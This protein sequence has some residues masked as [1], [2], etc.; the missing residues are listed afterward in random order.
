LIDEIGRFI[1]R[2]MNKDELIRRCPRLY[3]MAEAGSWPSIKQLGLLS[4]TAL[5]D[6]F[7]VKEPKR[8]QIESSW[9]PSSIPI[10]HPTFGKAI[11]RDQRPMPPEELEKCLVGMTVKEWY[12]YINR[13]TFFWVQQQRL[14]RLLNAFA[15][16]DRSHTVIIVDTNALIDNHSDRITLSNINSGFVYYGG[17]R[18]RDTFMS[19]ADFPSGHIVWELAV[20]Y[21]VDDI[22]QLAIRVE[23]W[24]GDQKL[25]VI[26]TR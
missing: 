19:L 5:L 23:E 22:A 9:R 17:Q 7:E 15:Y 25:G 16:R 1:N 10:T 6:K 13:R 11:I 14:L 2:K 21:S 20:D 8:A 3:H 26:W 12:K 24:K 4:T 18:G